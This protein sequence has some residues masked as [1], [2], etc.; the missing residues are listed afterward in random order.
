MIKTFCGGL[1]LVE[2]EPAVKGF[3]PG[4]AGVAGVVGTEGT[5][6]VVV[7]VHFGVGS[8]AFPVE[9]EGD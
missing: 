5:G 9:V 7:E 2:G 3:A 1:E 6:S 8:G 4:A